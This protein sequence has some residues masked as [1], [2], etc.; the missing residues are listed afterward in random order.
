MKTNSRPVPAV[1]IQR[2]QV[3]PVKQSNHQ[4]TFER[5]L[6]LV[7]KINTGIRQTATDSH[8]VN[9]ESKF[10]AVLFH[11]GNDLS[12]HMYG[13]GFRINIEMVETGNEE[14]GQS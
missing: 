8:E 4:L 3:Q 10:A 2:G 6:Q 12:M 5:F 1:R 14:G 9:P 11:R 7:D 13:A